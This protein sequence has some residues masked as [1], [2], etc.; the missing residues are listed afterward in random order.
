MTDTIKSAA[1]READ[2]CQK[3]GLELSE[4]TGGRASHWLELSVDGRI[5]CAQK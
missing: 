3:L 2:A 4:G 1:P 5:M